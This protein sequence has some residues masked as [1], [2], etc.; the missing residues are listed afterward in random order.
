MF[1][2]KTVF[3]TGATR[4]IGRAI[5]LMFAKH[6]ANVVITGKTTEPH[7]KLENTIHSVAEEVT[8][9]GGGALAL[10]L[11]IRDE[12]QIKSCVDKTVNTFGGIDILINNASAIQLLPTSEVSSK[13]YDLMMQI[14]QR[15]TFLCSQACIPHLKKS[16]SPHIIIMS[17]PMDMNPKWFGGHLAYTMSKYGMSMCTLGLSSELKSDGIAVNSLWPQTVIATAAVKNLFPE[18]YLKGARKP[19]IMAKAVEL[20]VQKNAEYTGK[21]LIDEQVL[22]ESGV[23]E[24]DEYAYV[25]GNPLQKD[26][27]L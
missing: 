26:L 13:G 10:Q 16:S 12:S 23:S 20:I 9:L 11:D 4:G 22:V 18:K 3:I 14:N 2:G 24:L 15:G 21:F 6:K 8:N 25:P 5:A 1:E 17:P 7:P 19:E 27:F